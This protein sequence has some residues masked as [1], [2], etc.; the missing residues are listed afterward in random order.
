MRK[1]MTIAIAVAVAGI[2]EASLA[3]EAMEKAVKARRGQMQLY[4]WNIGQL[5]A[6]AKGKVDYDAEVA[7]RAAKNLLAV[8]SMQDPL[9]WPEGSH[10]GNPALKGKTRTKEEAWTTWPKIGEASEAMITAATALNAAAGGGLSSLQGAIGDAGKACKACHED[11]R[12]KD[13]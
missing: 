2:A 5:G 11:F 12:A 1:L 9:L 3:D 8:V 4:G 7:S 10:N 13:F 6:M